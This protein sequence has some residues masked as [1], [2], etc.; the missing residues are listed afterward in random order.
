MIGAIWAQ[1]ADR[2]IGINGA[3]P[4]RYSGDFRRFKRLT[5]GSTVVMGRKTWES[6]GKP[7]PGRV[8]LVITRRLL[9][10]PGVVA[11]RGIENAIGYVNDVQKDLWVIGGAQVYEA[12]LPYCEILDVTYV[13]DHIDPAGAVLAPVIDESIWEPGDLLPHEDEPTLTR[14]VFRRRGAKSC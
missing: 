9:D 5:L 13:P 3:I 4:W 1:T 2:V 10:V 7:L 6:I 14:R 11:I 12:A 8:N